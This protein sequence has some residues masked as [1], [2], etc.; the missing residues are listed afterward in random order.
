MAADIT[1][2]EHRVSG[3][4]LCGA[5]TF[6]ALVTKR[7]I[8]VCHCEMCQR[9][10]A[11]PY[12]GVGCDGELTIEG[13]EN[14][15]VYKSSEWGERMFCRNCGS[16]LFWHLA[17]TNYYS[18]AAGALD[19]KSDL[20][21][22]LQIFIDEKPRY[23]EFANDTPKLTGAEAMATFAGGATENESNG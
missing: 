21:L 7:E 3:R 19:D 22:T 10:A 2:E 9:W 6:S 18:I 8:D 11:G 20:S 17:G 23:Y 5:V 4:C 15:G 13:R 16:S 14:L 12:F 1:R